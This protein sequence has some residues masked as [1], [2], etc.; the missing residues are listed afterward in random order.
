MF[1]NLSIKRKLTLII[2]MTSSLAV[3]VASVAVGIYDNRRSKQV[4]ARETTQLA[5]VIGSNSKA[6]LAFLDPAAAEEILSALAANEHITS[7]AIYDRDEQLFAVYGRSDR[8][9]LI[10]RPSEPG[11]ATTV[12]RADDF[13]VVRDMVLGKEIIGM[14]QIVSDLDELRSGTTRF[15]GLVGLILLGLSTATLMASVRLQQVITRPIQR[16]AAAT[17][18]ISNGD[19]DH[20]V[21]VT[22]N[23]ELGRLSHGFAVMLTRLRDYRAQADEARLGLEREVEQRTRELRQATAEAVEL[24]E[25]R[26]EALQMTGK[27]EVAKKAADAANAA[28]SQFLANMSH[29]IRTP[30]IGILG[31]TDLLLLEG[32]L[33]DEQRDQAETIRVSGDAMLALIN[34]ILDFSKIEAGKLTV[35]RVEFEPLTVV[36]DV[37]GLLAENA[38]AKGVELTP[39]VDPAVP[40]RA[41]GDPGRFRQVLTNL[42]G[43]AVKFT[44]EGDVTVTVTV[45]EKSTE[46]PLLR[47]EVQDNGIG[48]SPEAQ[49]KL[50]RPFSQVDGSTTRKF[51]GTGLGLA[52][53]KQLVELMGGD[54]G[55]ESQEGRGSTFWFTVRLG[56]CPAAP[57]DSLAPLAIARGASALVVDANSASQSRLT[58]LLTARGV[59]TDLASD[60]DA[61][62]TIVQEA[63]RSGRVHSLVV[64]SAQALPGQSETTVARPPCMWNGSETAP[65]MVLATRTTERVAETAWRAKGWAGT[66]VKPVRRGQLDTVL[67]SVFGVETSRSTTYASSVEAPSLRPLRV[68][69]AEDNAVNRKVAVL[70]LKKQGHRVDVAVDGREAVEAAS[71][72]AYDVILMDCQMPELDG[73]EA[74]REIRRLERPTRHTPVVALT[75][76]AMKGDRERCLEA[77]MDDYLS[78]PVTMAELTKVLE[79]SAA[80]S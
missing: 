20:D 4:L 22:T 10:L 61:A 74:T 53:S 40:T 2:V 46:L 17:E 70:M 14:V 32:G 47:F 52:I 60:I 7:A 24:A 35:E 28:K 67:A 9:D 18:A 33:T 65:P 11:V 56:Q 6:A 27:M 43:N 16:L 72:Q 75:A 79:R 42:A 41:L 31:M 49:R 62:K 66:L 26:R 51:G 57:T 64:I 38:H 12:F 5:S 3:L 58:Q 37:L 21:R 23:D 34:G 15:I 63:A 30:M 44:S 19:L 55:V 50:F 77:G 25:K 8:S 71:R 69:L 45:A 1:A 54:V 78:K 29:E 68:L 36:E 59:R 48:I 80:C 13:V 39:L 73:Y 76:N